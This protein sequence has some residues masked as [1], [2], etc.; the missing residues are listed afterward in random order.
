MFGGVVA[1]ARLTACK[2]TRF[3]NRHRCRKHHFK[4]F[5]IKDSISSTLQT[6]EESRGL[7]LVLV[8]L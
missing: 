8:I 7:S 3:S 1:S 6:I 5:K 4:V 2:Q